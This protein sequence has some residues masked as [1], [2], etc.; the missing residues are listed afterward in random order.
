MKIVYAIIGGIIF[1]LAYAV[2]LI[3]HRIVPG[4]VSGIAMILRFLYNTP[5]GIV[6]IILNIPLF[7]IALRV[8][9]IS[10]GIKSVGVII[11][12]NLLIDFL[13]Y[14][15]KIKTPTD[16]TVLAALYGGILLG[17][18]L[19]LIF[20]SDASTGGTDIA[21][22]IMSRYTN[23]SVGMWIMIVDFLVITT[24][25]ITTHSIELALL[26]YL[27][28]FLS[29]K[30]IDLVLEGIDY[31]RAA[32]VISNKADKITDEIY[33]KMRRG[34]TILDGHSPYSKEE[35]P[36]I[37]CVITKKQTPFFKSVV[38]NI[39]KDAFV[40]LTDVFEVLGKGFRSRV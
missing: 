13:V 35:K 1:A 25:G 11:Y 2:F 15:V 4:G 39:D 30:V 28:L 17:L 14:S 5:V 26:G 32:F 6:A 34:V 3:P 21:G 10:F 16:N 38:K 27:A 19:G 31:A 12:T 23:M 9:G 37:M 8:L 40:I 7:I 36:V 24:A 18:G 33:E 22:Q 29:S 20:R